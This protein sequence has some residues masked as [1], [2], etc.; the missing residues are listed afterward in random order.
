MGTMEG[1]TNKHRGNSIRISVFSS[2]LSKSTKYT[3]FYLSGGR[4]NG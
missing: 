1:K 3:K 4:Y 2:N